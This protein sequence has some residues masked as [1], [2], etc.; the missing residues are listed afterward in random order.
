[1]SFPIP[2]Q[3]VS[4]MVLYIWK[5]LN[6]PYISFNDLLYKLS[7]EL[8]L[9]SPNEAERF[10][11][12]AIKNQ[13]II[14]DENKNLKLSKKLNL[15]LLNWQNERKLDILAKMASYKIQIKLSNQFQKN[16]KNEFNIILKGFSD[17]STINRAVSISESAFSF[18]II[19]LD[20]G[21]IDATVKG[22]KEEAYILKIDLNKK[23]LKHNCH[24]FQ[25]RKSVEKKFCKHLVRLFLLLK[26]KDE[27]LTASFL[28]RIA[29][30][31]EEIE[32]LN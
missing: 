17:K 16:S 9:Y 23:K 10:I 11:S 15:A 25:T 28:K 13:F 3:K 14:Q 18:R 32:F 21:L 26:E 19:N 5:I 22:S 20:K 1:M 7:F 2:R 29:D 31:I 8:F 24:D 27:N 6:F 4:E 12:N 30:E